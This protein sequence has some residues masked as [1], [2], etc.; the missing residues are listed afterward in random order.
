MAGGTTEVVAKRKDLQIQNDG[1]YT[2]SGDLYAVGN[3]T[4]DIILAVEPDGEVSGS[5]DLEGIFWQIRP[6]DKRIHMLTK[7]NETALAERNLARRD[8][9]PEYGSATSFAPPQSTQLFD[10]YGGLLNA[11]CTR[12]I[13]RLLVLYTA[14][15]AQ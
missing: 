5:I 1:S 14:A 11:R 6:L 7:V 3:Y 10:G 15:A 12:E 13:I 4:G 9:Q 2:W 8:Q